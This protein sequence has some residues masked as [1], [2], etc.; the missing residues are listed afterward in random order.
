MASVVWSKELDG[1]PEYIDDGPCPPG[2]LSAPSA[3]SAVN[4]FC[5]AL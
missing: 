2:G 4:H 1:L 5:M 3:F